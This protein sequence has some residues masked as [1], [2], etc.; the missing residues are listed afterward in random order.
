ME[1]RKQEETQ[2][3]EAQEEKVT[4]FEKINNFV[5]DNRKLVMGVS[6]GIIAAV[7]LIFVVKSILEKNSAEKREKAETAISRILPFYQACLQGDSTQVERALNGDPQFKVRGE[8]VIGLKEIANRYEGI[9]TGKVAA[10]YAGN[11]LLM[12]KRA[13]EAEHYFKIA[14]DADP[15]VILEGANAG[16]GVA[17]EMEGKIDD[18]ISYYDKAVKYADSYGSKSRYE[19]FSGLLY[20]QNG[21]KDQA[22][23]MYRAIIGENKSGEF[24]MKAKAGLTRLGIIIE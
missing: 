2:H 18:A 23:K 16:M 13:D 24:V 4:A 6:I 1:E 10:L 7:I 21:K 20:E 19:Y 14:L 8:N 22:E 3:N 12:T 5:N 11:L 15:K 9:S 17:K